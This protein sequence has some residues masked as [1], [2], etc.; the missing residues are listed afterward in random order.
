MITGKAN[1]Q[2]SGSIY[3]TDAS[4]NFIFRWQNN[5]LDTIIS[6]GLGFPWRLAADSSYLYWTSVDKNLV[7]RAS[8]DGSNRQQLA[9]ITYPEGIAV[10][11]IKGDVYISD[12]GTPAIIRLS[13]P[14]YQ[15]DTLYLEELI[16]P[17][18]IILNSKTNNLYWIDVA[19][20]ELVTG[21]T[22]GDKI[23]ILLSNDRY[24]PTAIAL[25]KDNGLLYWA[26]GKQKAIY[27]FNLKTA[28][29][30]QITNGLQKPT[31][32]SY[33]PT[34]NML[35]W[36]DIGNKTLGWID[37]DSSHVDHIY[38]DQISNFHSGMVWLH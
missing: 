1:G 14:G 33:N 10:D 20:G 19:K 37:L 2:P 38:L 36:L 29:I 6:E 28:I 24:D 23:K 27:S 32:I 11:N 15:P 4:Y 34:E 18:N 21:N 3:F 7:E 9:V 8:L 12:P 22:K 31:A 25:D 5:K 16:D 30:Q 35:V 13:P 17:D 26:D